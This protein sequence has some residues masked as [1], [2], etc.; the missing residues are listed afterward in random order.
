MEMADHVR[1]MKE[2]RALEEEILFIFK[3][4][5]PNANFDSW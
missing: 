4:D 2:D 5:Y 3:R 1:R